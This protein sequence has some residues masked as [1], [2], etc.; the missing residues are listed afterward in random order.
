MS[1]QALNEVLPGPPEGYCALRNNCFSYNPHLSR[2][3]AEGEI[4]CC[5][6]SRGGKSGFSVH[7]IPSNWKCNLLEEMCKSFLGESCMKVGSLWKWES[8]P[9]AGKGTA[10]DNQRKEM[11]PTQIKWGRKSQAE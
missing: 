2:E 5:C 7:W 9:R 8:S 11:S 10:H 1:A 4:K 6:V 3:G